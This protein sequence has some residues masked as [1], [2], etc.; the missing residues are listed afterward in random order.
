MD[1]SLPTHG[2]NTETS[3]GG[4]NIALIIGPL[5][6]LVTIGIL[7][8]ITGIFLSVLVVI[9]PVVIGIVWLASYVA[10][11]YRKAS[12]KNDKIK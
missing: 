5:I 6:V 11:I 3:I 10:Y 9:I 7:L 2:D 8:L 12:H 1:P 4:K